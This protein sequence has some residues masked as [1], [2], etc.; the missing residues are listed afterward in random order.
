MN[1]RFAEPCEVW[2]MTLRG[3]RVA[4]AMVVPRGLDLR[5]LWFIDGVPQ[6]GKTVLVWEDAVRAAD[7]YRRR[8]ET[9]CPATS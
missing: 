6:D 9:D 5:V 4:H 2:R 8:A 1:Y 7:S 3:G